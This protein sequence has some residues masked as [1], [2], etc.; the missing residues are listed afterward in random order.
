VHYFIDGYNLLFYLFQDEKPLK[1]Q[2][3][4]L[5]D[6]LN[7]AAE[8]L[9]LH[10]T[11][12]FDAHYHPENYIRTHVS[13]LEIIYTDF[14]ESADAYIIDAVSMASHPASITVVT[15][16]RSLARSVKKEGAH[17]ES[18]KAFF[19]SLHKRQTKQP[20]KKKTEKK[21][22][23]S[24]MKTVIEGSVEYYLKKFLEKIDQEN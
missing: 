10:L 9:N 16:D 21:Q 18:T 24:P 13:H 11:V 23:L 20:R 22:I 7:E 12:V 3:D 17:T 1:G 6:I 4:E 14:G 2:R 5:I 19:R 8:T 15:H